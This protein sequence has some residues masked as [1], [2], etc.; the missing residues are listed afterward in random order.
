MLLLRRKAMAYNEKSTRNIICRAYQES[1]MNVNIKTQ[2]KPNYDHTQ[3]FATRH[4]FDKGLL[5]NNPMILK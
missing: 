3:G 1:P 5:E 4:G 2:R